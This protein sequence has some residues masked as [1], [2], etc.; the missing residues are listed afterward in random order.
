MTTVVLVEDNK[1][2]R[3][4]LRIAFD[5]KSDEFHFMK[6]FGDAES[7]LQEIPAMNPEVV[8]MDINLPGITG[9]ECMK[10]LKKIIPSL[11]VI[12]LTVFAE[13]KTVFDAL[14]FGACGYNIV[15]RF[16]ISNY[17][18]TFIFG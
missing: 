5:Q 10:E 1:D 6:S 13:D 3:D 12:M 18:E 16:A 8:L 4:I 15:G 11:N 9:I 17:N 7:A 2:L 14:C